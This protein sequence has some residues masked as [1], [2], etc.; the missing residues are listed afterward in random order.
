[1]LWAVAHS[2]AQ[3][4]EAPAQNPSDP[5]GLGPVI[6]ISK[7]IRYGGSGGGS[8][9]L[10]VSGTYVFLNDRSRVGGI[11]SDTDSAVID[12]TPAL[13]VCPYTSFNVGYLYAGS[14]GSSPIGIS[15]RVNESSMSLRILQ[16]IAPLLQ[17]RSWQP[18]TLDHSLPP[19][20]FQSA[21][22][23][24]GDYGWLLSSLDAPHGRSI[25]GSVD[26]FSSNALF[27]FQFAY[28][29]NHPANYI[30]PNLLIEGTT[31]F[32]FATLRF[33]PASRA[34]TITSLNH[35]VVYRHIWSVTY[36]PFPLSYIP[37][38]ACLYHLGFLASVELDNPIAVEP[39]RGSRPFY[40]TTAVFTGGLVYN[41]YSTPHFRTGKFDLGNII[42]GFGDLDAWTISLS[43]SYK[44]FDPL[45]ETNLLQVQISHAF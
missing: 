18:V 20:H 29:V 39:S 35:E 26:P 4:H 42:A 6:D 40:A 14:T 41:F 9:S 3:T 23:L 45:T 27:D 7:P 44:A 1:M 10:D 43:Y 13:T 37:I 28:I 17:D 25:H 11:S 15:Q 32:Q 8:W 38:P 36:S 24:S 5:F 31:G 16:P 34:S 21:F 12:F 33:G 19:I 30:Y 22:S 2:S